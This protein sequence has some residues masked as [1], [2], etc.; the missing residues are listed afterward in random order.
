M[1]CLNIAE[2]APF[3]TH[4]SLA[5]PK[6]AAVRPQP[7]PPLP[8]PIVHPPQRPAPR[9]VRTQAPE[10]LPPITATRIQRSTSD[11]AIRG[12]ASLGN[13]IYVLYGRERDQLDELDAHNLQVR[14]RR[15]S[16]SGI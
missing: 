7:P 9:P 12:I 14:R 11:S 13:R 15:L 2:N 1:N 3:N 5:R 4:F 6:T 8:K 10:T 16:V